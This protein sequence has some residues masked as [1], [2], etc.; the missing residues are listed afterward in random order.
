MCEDAI[1]G[2]HIIMNIQSYKPIFCTLQ[3]RYPKRNISIGMVLH[4]NEEEIAKSIYV[5]YFREH[6]L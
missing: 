2:H 6:Q 1:E 3:S 5:G 4:K